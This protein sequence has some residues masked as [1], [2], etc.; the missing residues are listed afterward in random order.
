MQQLSEPVRTSDKNQ[1][2]KEQKGMDLFPIMELLR[3]EPF[4]HRSWVSTTEGDPSPDSC[5]E[6]DMTKSV[7]VFILL[8]GIGLS[9]SAIAQEPCVPCGET[10]TQASAKDPTS[11]SQLRLTC[12]DPG[13]P[14]PGSCWQFVRCCGAD[15]TWLYMKCIYHYCAEWSW[16]DWHCIVFGMCPWCVDWRSGIE[17]G[18]FPPDGWPEMAASSFVPE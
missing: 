3:Q 7:L 10:N 6:R 15:G 2:V 8:V 5:K 16:L 9:W 18:C 17:Y 14:P 11:S 12:V 1:E 13:N 4:F